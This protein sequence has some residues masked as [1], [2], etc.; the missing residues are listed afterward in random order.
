MDAR[1][2]S[3]DSTDRTCGFTCQCPDPYAGRRCQLYRRCFADARL[4]YQTDYEKR[5]YVHAGEHCRRQGD[6][7]KPI[8]LSRFESFDLRAFVED[9]PLKQLIRGPVWLAAEARQVPSDVTA[10]W[11]WLDGLGTSRRPVYLRAVS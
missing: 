3:G 5:G 2:C 7:T 9:D 10:Y 1:Q 8:V 6:L 11:Q 4:C